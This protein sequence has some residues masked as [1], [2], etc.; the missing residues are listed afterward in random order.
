MVRGRSTTNQEWAERL[1]ERFFAKVSG[2]DVNGCWNWTGAKSALGYGYFQVS[3]QQ[4]TKLA[5]RVA[6]SLER[7]DDIP[8][9][10]SV[11]HHCDNPS[12]VNPL[13]L[14]VARHAENMADCFA[15]GRHAYGLRV[16]SARLNEGLVREMRRAAAAGEHILSIASRFDISRR[17]ASQAVSGETWK[18][19]KDDA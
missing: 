7:G 18:H 16:H 14:S 8:Q 11:M 19:V 10:L 17:S 3:P 2:P 9:E 13:H 1:Q 6:V 15:K 5:H 4:G 12:C